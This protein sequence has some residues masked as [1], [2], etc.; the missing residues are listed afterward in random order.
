MKNRRVGLGLLFIFLL[1]PGALFAQT[2]SCPAVLVDPISTQQACAG[3]EIFL[4]IFIDDESLGRLVWSFPDGTTLDDEFS[5]TYTVTELEP[6]NHTQTISWFLVCDDIEDVVDNG[7]V[8]VNT[9]VLPTEVTNDG[10]VI[11]LVGGDCPDITVTGGNNSAGNIF[12]AQEGESG[13]VVFDIVNSAAPAECNTSQVSESFDCM[14]SVGSPDAGIIE[15][16]VFLEGYILPDGTM[17]TN[18][19]N[20]DLLPVSQPFNSFPYFFFGGQS[21]AAHADDTVDWLLVEL[22]DQNDPTILVERQA[23]LLRNDGMVVDLNGDSE[24]QW[25]SEGSFHLV[26]K[27]RSHLGIQT[28][29]AIDN[30]TGATY[31]FSTSIDQ[32]AGTE[33]QVLNNGIAAMST[34]DYDGNGTVNFG[35]FIRWLSNNNVIEIYNSADGDGNGTINFFDFIRFLGNN[36]KVSV[37]SIP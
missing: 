30:S 21:V 35:D 36:N 29:T 12:T 28:A 31:D 24:I 25:N 3:E 4:D 1:C 32:A 5:T 2:L 17:R 26:V 14:E 10:C 22:R 34:G 9:F 23:L 19:A 13:T 16:K 8:T 6:C 20:N 27:Q 37:P 33:Q 7:T 15:L 18:L 11:E